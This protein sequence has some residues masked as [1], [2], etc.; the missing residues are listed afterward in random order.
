[1]RVT[2]AIDATHDEVE[3]AKQ[4]AL[5]LMG[6][7]KETMDLFYASDLE[8]IEKGIKRLNEFSS[9]SWLVSAL[10]LYTMIFNNSLYRDSGLDWRH[11]TQQARER[12]GLD[13]RDI[14]DQ[15]CAARFFIRHHEKME[16][17]GF[18]FQHISTS[19][20]A[21]A[22]LAFSLC[23]NANEVIKKLVETKSFAEFREW[24]QS[25]KPAKKLL[26]NDRIRKEI[27]PKKFSINGIRAVEISADIPEDD[28]LRLKNYIKEI[29]EVMAGGYE[30]AIIPVYDKKEA[31]ALVSLRDKRRRE[32]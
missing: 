14:T 18:D 5:Q 9:K 17:A 28:Q 1:M 13:N 11:Y 16:K 8:D 15:L 7:Q 2:R 6:S 20:L 21:R 32:R 30:P 31:K 22:E 26:D 12:L 19:K 29:M 27:E 24:Y 3:S 4:S 25:L 10:L 23:K